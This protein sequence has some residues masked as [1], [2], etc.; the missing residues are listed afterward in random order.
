MALHVLIAGGGRVGAALAH[1]LRADGHHTTVVE[2]RSERFDELRSNSH[3]AVVCGD[4]TDPAVLETAGVHTCDVVAAVTGSDVDNL[5][6]AGLARFEFGAPRT[7]AR[8]VDPEHAW[9]FTGD[10]GVDVAVDQADVIA[11]LVAEELD[12]ADLTRLVQGSNGA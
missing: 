3:G 6:V 8:V 2:I 10:L 12:L 1:R 11:L 5:V 7:V 4:A 9:L